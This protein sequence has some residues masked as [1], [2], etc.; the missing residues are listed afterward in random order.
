MGPVCSSLGVQHV[1]TARQLPKHPPCG[2]ASS[3]H[4]LLQ[5]LSFSW[6]PAG[7]LETSALEVGNTQ[8]ILSLG[9]DGQRK[10]AQAVGQP[11]LHV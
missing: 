2:A 9:F 10:I 11:P 8:G 6:F 7:I 1:C 4:L 3:L 5:V